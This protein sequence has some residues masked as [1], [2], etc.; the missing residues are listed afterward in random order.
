MAQEQIIPTH[1]DMCEMIQHVNEMTQGLIVALDNLEQSHLNSDR[2]EDREDHSAESGR[3]ATDIAAICAGLESAMAIDTDSVHLVRA[4]LVQPGDRVQLG[5]RDRLSTPIAY[6]RHYRI[7]PGY[8]V[9]DKATIEDQTMSGASIIARISIDGRPFEIINN[10]DG[11]NPSYLIGELCQA[12]DGG[13]DLGACSF[14]AESGYLRTQHDN[15]PE[16]SR[17]DRLIDYMKPKEATQ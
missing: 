3:L 9:I 16:P 5:D 7:E 2:P 10:R 15:P 12:C 8:H 6:T 13:R 14:C 1:S 11:A 4:E 17:F